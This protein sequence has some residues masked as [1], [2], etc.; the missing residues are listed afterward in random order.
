MKFTL[1]PHTQNRRMR[2]AAA[3][4]RN[5]VAPVRSFGLGRAGEGQR[6]M[7]L[8]DARRLTT[9]PSFSRIQ[10]AIGDLDRQRLLKVLTGFHGTKVLSIRFQS[11][12]LPTTTE[13]KDAITVP[14]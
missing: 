1:N 14:A 8:R 13:R 2:H 6:V 5:Y 10:R 12:L 3:G 9:Q 7:P 11:P 4:R